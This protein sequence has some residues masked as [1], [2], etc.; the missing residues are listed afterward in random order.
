MKVENLDQAN[1][2]LKEKFKKVFRNF[3]PSLLGQPLRSNSRDKPETPPNPNI[4][5]I[6]SGTVLKYKVIKTKENIRSQLNQ[7][8]TGILK[9]SSQSPC[10]ERT[11]EFKPRLALSKKKIKVYRGK[12]NEDSKLRK[13]L[14]L[15]LKNIQGI[16][17]VKNHL[18]LRKGRF[19][20]AKPP[21]IPRKQILLSK[22]RIKFNPQKEDDSDFNSIC[23]DK[24][25]VEAIE[26]IRLLSNYKRKALNKTKTPSP[27]DRPK[28]AWEEDSITQKNENSESP[29]RNLYAQRHSSLSVKRKTI[30]SF[31]K[32]NIPPQSIVRAQSINEALKAIKF[33][34]SPSTPK[35]IDF[36][37]TK[38]RLNSEN[39]ATEKKNRAGRNK[40]ASPVEKR[41]ESSKSSK[42]F[43][44]KGRI[45]K[46]AQNQSIPACK[47]KPESKS[48]PP[49]R[50]GGVSLVTKPVNS[51]NKILKNAFVKLR[52]RNSTKA[53]ALKS[54]KTGF[55]NC[56]ASKLYK[57][58]KKRVK[59]IAVK[60][61]NPQIIRLFE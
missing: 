41:S 9:A 36:H 18:S 23:T 6:W 43:R 1:R 46:V 37:C 29:N 13:K 31:R 16:S 60:P 42:R 24:Q 61:K 12:S 56:N 33:D 7:T 3:H 22:E 54:T 21:K 19:Q 44:G 53:A 2:A 34:Q 51:S 25:F 47:A 49:V 14:Y 11:S 26:N 50:P 30:K 5:Q 27:A 35:K 17:S 59:N 8:Q 48:K 55:N 40:T 39:L 38:K 32:L 4:I 57:F 52:T 45:Y 58:K 20:G 15:N 28:E 10:M